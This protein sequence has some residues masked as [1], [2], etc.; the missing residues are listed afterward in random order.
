MDHLTTHQ[1]P[2][3]H[4]T[5]GP[6]TLCAHP[7]HSHSHM[8]TSS[9]RYLFRPRA[10]PLFFYP[11]LALGRG[12]PLSC[13]ALRAERPSKRGG[14]ELDGVHQGARAGR[15]RGKCRHRGSSCGT[16][17]LRSGPGSLLGA[18]RAP[19]PVI[20]S[21]LVRPVLRGGQLLA[22]ASTAAPSQPWACS[23]SPGATQLQSPECSHS[24][25]AAPSAIPR[26]NCT[27]R[28]VPAAQRSPWG[29]PATQTRP[30]ALKG[31][32]PRAPAPRT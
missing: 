8:H 20:A 4:S 18:Q 2:T 11:G 7:Y 1:S 5:G 22:L 9:H 26:P 19:D 21:L 31:R 30:H 16:R 23:L 29:A 27:S 28:H 15:E 14:S 25:V 10:F 17:G 24:P 32:V 6:L 3:Q 13:G 12:S